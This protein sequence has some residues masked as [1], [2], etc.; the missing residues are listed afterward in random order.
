MSDLAAAA[1]ALGIPELLVQ[2][3][4]EARAAETGAS[5]EEV[6]AAWAG[7]ESGPAPAAKPESSQPEETG[8]TT[9]DAAEP[10]VEPAAP[11]V[12]IEIP[13]ERPA[14][15]VPAVAVSRAPGPTEVT[16]AEAAN[17]PVVITVPTSGIK[18]RTNSAVPKWLAVTFFIAPL[19]ALFALGSSATGECGTATELETNVITGEIVNCDGSEFTGSA[20]GGGETDFIALGEAIYQGSELSGV[21]CAGC[22]G[23][24]G[25]GGAGPALNAVLTVFGSC[26]DHTE[27]VSLATAGLQAAGRSTYGDTNKPLGGFGAGMP[28]FGSLL[29]EEQI[30]AVSAF[31][32]VRFGGQEPEA[33]LSD[34]GL[35]EDP[36][37]GEGEEGAGEDGAIVDQPPDTTDTGE[38]VPDQGGDGETGSGG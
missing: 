19:L 22:H 36:E 10:D 20:V 31:E 35:A 3:S 7:G 17:L 32:R 27:W 25:G 38:G 5:V 30:A 18:E 28:G 33:A 21:N 8:T 12:T 6:L 13:D 11:E 23:A 4:A 2:R 1:A 29:S 9:E 14:D 26:A 24:G 34:C 37:E 16:A 15:R